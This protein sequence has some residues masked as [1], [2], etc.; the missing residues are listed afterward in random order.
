MAGHDAVQRFTGLDEHTRPRVYAFAVSHAGRELAEEIVSEVYL[1]AWRRLADIPR[2]ELPWLL[3]VARNVAANQF[4]GHGPAAP[5]C[6]R[7]LSTRRMA[8]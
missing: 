8:G 6:S 1:I 4:R 2:P 7:P 5:S 3:S